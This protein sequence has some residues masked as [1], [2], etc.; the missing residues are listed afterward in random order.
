METL[1]PSLLTRVRKSEYYHV[2]HDI[3]L[4]QWFRTNI[5]DFARVA[6]DKKQNWGFFL[7]LSQKWVPYEDGIHKYGL[8]PMY[9]IHQDS[10]ENRGYAHLQIPKNVD[11]L[12][13]F[14]D[15]LY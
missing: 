8:T 1:H 15:Y 7:P 13:P 14:I 6:K 9:P 4:F 10:I 3:A 11:I 2:A 5:V 12:Y